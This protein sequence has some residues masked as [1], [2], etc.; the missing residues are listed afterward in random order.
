MVEHPIDPKKQRWSFCWFE[1]RYFVGFHWF[2][3]KHCWCF[4]WFGTNFFILKRTLLSLVFLNL[5]IMKLI[6]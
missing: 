6:W 3:T 4:R 1:T 5:L 2:E